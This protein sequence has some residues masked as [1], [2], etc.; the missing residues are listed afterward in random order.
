[1]INFVG[2]AWFRID[3]NKGLLNYGVKNVKSEVTDS[4]VA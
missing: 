3:S 2:F 1:M 4:S